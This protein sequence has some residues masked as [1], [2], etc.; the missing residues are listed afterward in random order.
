[1]SSKNFI[2]FLCM[3]KVYLLSAEGYKNAEVDAK[4]VRKAGKIWASMKDVRIGMG[5]KNISDLVLKELRGALKTKNPT[6]E[7]ISQYKITERELYEKFD[8]LSEEELNTKSNKT[9]YV[10]SDVKTTIIKRCRGEKKRGIGAIDGFRKKLMIPD[11]EIPV[12]PEFEVKSKIVKL[13]TNEKILEEYSVKIYG[14]DPFFM[15]ITKK[16]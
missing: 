10:R 11:S 12:C 2:F 16:K 6:K 5:V 14:I 9:V 4:I 1:M 7:Q 13:F 8:N 15:S 3:Y